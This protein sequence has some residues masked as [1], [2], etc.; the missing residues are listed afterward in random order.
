MY[1][2]FLVR[3]DSLRNYTENGRVAGFC[4]GVRI[5]NYRGV[6]LS[7]HNGY[8][9]EVDGESYPVALQRFGVNGKPPR[10][11]EELK[12]HAVYEHW[13]MQ[14]EATLYITKEGGLTPG[15]HRVGIL[16][17]ILCS[18]GRMPNDEETVKHPPVPAPNAGRQGGGGSKTTDVSYFD[19]ELQE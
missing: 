9:V 18:Y 19:L 6:F 13:D 2:S 15:V 10:S 8:Y 7:L 11:F 12:N 1:D 5:A 4:F 17:S 16:E 3:G 14:D